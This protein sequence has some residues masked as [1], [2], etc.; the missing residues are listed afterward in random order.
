M[1]TERKQSG[2][3]KRASALEELPSSAKQ[4]ETKASSGGTA[5]R[6]GSDSS[7]TQGEVAAGGLHAV[8]ERKV[9]V[10]EPSDVVALPGGSFLVVGDLSDKVGLVRADGS[11]VKIKL[12]G[13]IKD[14]ES[15]LEAVTYDTAHKELLVVSETEGMLY[16]YDL[17]LEAVPIDPEGGYKLELKGKVALAADGSSNKGI[18]GMAYLEASQSPT[19]SA[20]VIVAKEGSPRMLAFVDRDTGELTPIALDEAVREA[21]KDFSALAVDPRTGN[22]FIASDE[23][24]AVAEIELSG[25][26]ASSV[27]GSLVQ[28]YALRDLKGAVVKRLEG[29]AF[30]EDGALHGLLEDKRTLL[31][32]DRG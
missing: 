14:G 3:T 8:R 24:G 31:Q 22:L 12:G 15:G 21:C 5:G 6:A 7:F 13:K 26:K 32:F 10:K 9:D 2:S 23:S 4:Q 17:D 30:D 20:G 1:K 25:K 27:S 18:E 16:R 29:I 11:A 28:A 19:G